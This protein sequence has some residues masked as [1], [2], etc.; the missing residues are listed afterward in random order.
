MSEAPV[1]RPTTLRRA[2]ISP[3]GFSLWS[4]G[5]RPFY[6]LA[7]IFSVFSVLLWTAQFS[8]LLPS[9]YL[10]SSV[11]HAHEMLF[12]Y[13]TAIIA[14]FLLTAVRAWTNQPTARGLPLMA[15]TGLWFAGRVLV[16]TPFAMTATLVN[17]AFPA[18]V[19]VAIGIPLRR[20]RNVRN[21]FFVGLL[22]LMSALIFAVH[23]ASQGEI[24]LSPHL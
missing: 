15:L 24:E 2:L 13:V 23:L 14:G 22:V 19:A 3:A 10:H 12:G 21:Y 8:G 1:T 16:L 7:A 17:A 18:A 6:L 11:W 20:S 4:L 5:F 9:A